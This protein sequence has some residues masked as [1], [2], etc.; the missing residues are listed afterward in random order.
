[1]NK[2]IF[3]TILFLIASAVS[4]AFRSPI[5]P[6]ARKSSSSLKMISLTTGALGFMGAAVG[7]IA[8]FNIDNPIDITDRGKQLSKRKRIDDKKANG[9]FKEADPNADPYRYRIPFIDEDD[10]VDI[11]IIN[12]GK[13]KSGGCG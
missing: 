3:A 12:G 2:I 4:N 5:R 11:A 1:M 9:T 8:I 6:F 7:I 10:D 13:K